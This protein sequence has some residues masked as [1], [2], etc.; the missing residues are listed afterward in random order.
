[1]TLNFVKQNNVFNPEP[2]T[3]T[4]VL[5]GTG[6]VTYQRNPEAAARATEEQK[7]IENLAKKYTEAATAAKADV[8][9]KKKTHELAQ[10]NLTAASADA[11]SQLEQAATT[12]KAAFDQAQQKSTEAE[13]KRA[14]GEKEKTA[15]IAR[16]KAA[17]TAAA[18]KDTKFATW[19]L[20]ITVEVKPAPEKK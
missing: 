13:A 9:A 19:S 10:K 14:Q 6:V 16:A 8:E 18:A 3:W 17:T 5:K 2:G 20:P 7:H 4:F 15:A 12:A 11:K 1:M